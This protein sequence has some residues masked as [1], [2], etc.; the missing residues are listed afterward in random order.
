LS[1]STQDF[2]QFFT[3]LAS[4]KILPQSTLVCPDY[5]KNIRALL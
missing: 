2:D 3:R 1:F 4:H 5:L